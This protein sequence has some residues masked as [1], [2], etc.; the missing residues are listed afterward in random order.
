MKYA[1]D[2]YQ[3]NFQRVLGAPGIVKGIIGLGKSIDPN[4]PQEAKSAASDT[5]LFDEFFRKQTFRLEKALSS[6][7]TADRYFSG[8]VIS[9]FDGRLGSIDYR[10]A[11]WKGYLILPGDGAQIECVFDR[12]KGENEFN[13]FGNKRV[14]ITGRAIYT[15]DSLLP[16]RIEVTSISEFELA[17]QAVDIRGSLEG[18][19]YGVGGAREGQS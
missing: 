7:Y 18:S 11:V 2:V 10:D 14:S 17:R 19:Q 5:L 15:G 4:F 8:V 1:D 16:E 9:T 3:G 12:K 6:G 13:R